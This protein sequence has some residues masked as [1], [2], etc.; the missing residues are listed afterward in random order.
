MML[1]AGVHTGTRNSD[2]MMT[3]YIWRRCSESIF[4][5]FEYRKDVGKLVLVARIIVAIENP[6]DVI[7][8]SARTYGMRAVLKFANFT[9]AESIARIRS[10]RSSRNRVS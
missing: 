1:S 6:E 5:I 10:P 4:N 3:E 7:S 8:I 2:S 9:G